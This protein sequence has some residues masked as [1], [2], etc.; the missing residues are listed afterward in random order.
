MS[1]DQT[2]CVRVMASTPK[3]LFRGWLKEFFQA[4]L[5]QLVGRLAQW[6]ISLNFLFPRTIRRIACSEIEPEAISLSPY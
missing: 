1:S 6:E 2:H 4:E 5:P 3:H